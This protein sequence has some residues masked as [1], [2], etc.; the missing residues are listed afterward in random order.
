MGQ[1]TY[2]DNEAFRPSSWAWHVALEWIT[3]SRHE[4]PATAD[5]RSDLLPARCKIVL[6][7]GL[8]QSITASQARIADQQH[9]ES[10]ANVSQILRRQR[11]QPLSRYVDC[12]LSTVPG[13]GPVHGTVIGKR[14]IGCAPVLLFSW[15]ADWF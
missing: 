9:M 6:A 5:C 7:F 15:N 2:L 3:L 14:G 13:G 8:W 10:A 11:N 12:P 4:R 1:S